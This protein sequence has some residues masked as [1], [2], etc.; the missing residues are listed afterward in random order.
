MVF[1]FETVVAMMIATALVFT[2]PVGSADE[3]ATESASAAISCRQENMALNEVRKELRNFTGDDAKKAE[4]KEDL[5]EVK[6]EYDECVD[7]QALNGAGA[8][9]ASTSAKFQTAK[10]EFST[11]CGTANIDEGDK[12][13]GSIACSDSLA[14]CSCISPNTTAPICEDVERAP[15]PRGKISDLINIRQKKDEYK[16]CPSLATVDIENVERQLREAKA[17]V[18]ALEKEATAARQA[19]AD[20]LSA[21]EET[22]NGLHTEMTQAKKEQSEAMAAIKKEK[23]AQEQQIIAQATEVQNQMLQLDEAIQT[24]KFQST[25]ASVEYEEQIKQTELICYQSASEGV[26]RLQQARLAQPF[27]RGGFNQMLKAVGVSDRAAWQ[28]EAKKLYNYC[29]NSSPTKAQKDSAYKTYRQKLLA[30]TEAVAAL[31]RQKEA[32]QVELGRIR[33]SGGCAEGTDAEG[34]S[35]ATT[36]CQAQKQALDD[37]ARTAADHRDTLADISNRGRTAMQKASRDAAT[38]NKEALEKELQVTEERTRIENLKQFLA[39]KQKEGNSDMSVDKDQYQD[40]MGKY[41]GLVAIA[42][43]VVQTCPEG[44]NA[45]P[46]LAA[47][48]FLTSLKEE[49]PK[50]IDTAVDSDPS[51]DTPPHLEPREDATP[52][53]TIVEETEG[54]T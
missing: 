6:R 8:T 48:N 31:E 16:M 38:K 4:I 32:K 39:L 28:R 35:T 11:A 23:S 46:C 17:A 47:K 26:G 29:L 44:C 21:K 52:R 40:A 37:L 50:G 2:A 12:P 51:G 27:N 34:A 45:G 1:K 15:A 14:K 49:I 10:T 33:G 30:S 20:I 18:P 5:E 22:M 43:D 54:A 7:A 3:E 19:A 42:K 36:M 9:C 41:K 53:D 25:T 24:A 13:T